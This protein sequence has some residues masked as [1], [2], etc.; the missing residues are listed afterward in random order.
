MPLT[1][2]LH[3]GLTSKRFKSDNLIPW[4]MN[5]NSRFF[6]VLAAVG[7]AIGLGNL[8]AYPYL[9]FRFTGL[10]FIPYI[11]ALFLLG[12]PLLML[13]FSIGQYFN[14]NV[15]DL[16]ASVRKRLSGIG[17]L[18][19]VNAFIVMSF[20]AVAL[21][22]PIVYLFVSFGQ[23]WKNNASNYFFSNVVQISDGLTNFTQFSLPAFIA[24][25]I[26]WLIVFFCIKNGFESMKRWFLATIPALIVL[27]LLFLFYSL[28][29]QASLKGIYYFL[30]PNFRSLLS[31]NVWIS[32]FSLVMMSLGLGFGVMHAFAR[33]SGKGFVAGNSFIVPVFEIIFSVALGFIAFGILGF[34]SLKE[35]IGL[36]ST[37]FPGFHFQFSV[38][39]QAFP[40][41]YRPTLLS[42]LFFVF[43]AAIFLLGTASLAYSVS[44]L[45]V[46]KFKTRHFNAAVI[47]A[48][49]GFLL[50]F[51]FI[52]KPGFYIM[53]I[54]SHFVYYNILIAA[55]LECLAVGWFFDSEKISEF[56]N[57]HSFLKI[58][59]IW[60]FF[61][62]YFVPLVLIALL[63]I[64]IKSDYLLKFK[65]YPIWAVLVFGTGSVA[66]PIIAAFLLP[67]KILDRR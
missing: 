66:V 34:L 28:S 42:I 54:V 43:L 26:A 15:V 24:L 59:S 56:I 3:K 30:K 67:R 45:L 6:F 64:Q 2:F 29:L 48:G 61:I 49:F 8:W 33:K 5:N 19:S 9:S 13:A 37:A 57:H 44:H 47:V 4:L 65:G 36:D 20:Y 39:A 23:Q 52:I 60:R 51:L 53:E 38:L 32:S 31:P 35:G 10:F 7:A 11:I 21:S 12:I 55:F 46:H 63:A 41:F 14:K 62:R 25:I 40:L 58:G 50:G 17:W 22:W 27:V 1:Y 18:M 16:F